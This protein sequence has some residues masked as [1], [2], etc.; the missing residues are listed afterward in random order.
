MSHLN[1]AQS[2]VT[3]NV[4]KFKLKNFLTILCNFHSLKNRSHWRGLPL[5]HRQP[6]SAPVQQADTAVQRSSDIAW[7]TN[8]PCLS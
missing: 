5:Q 3:V 7:E 8:C 2:E 4:F 6:K 1:E